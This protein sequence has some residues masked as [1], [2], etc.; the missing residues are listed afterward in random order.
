MCN[1][2][3]LN[4]NKKYSPQKIIML[5]Y[6]WLE[7]CQVEAYKCRYKLVNSSY[8][9]DTKRTEKQKYDSCH[10]WLAQDRVFSCPRV[11]GMQLYSCTRV[12]LAVKL[13][14]HSH[15]I[16]QPVIGLYRVLTTAVYKHLWLPGAEI[17]INTNCGGGWPS[18]FHVH[19]PYFL[20]IRPSPVSGSISGVQTFHTFYVWSESVAHQIMN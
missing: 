16:Y 8:K 9:C 5:P 7:D 14:P 13:H 11:T 2:D 6:T 3:L 15:G 17:L 20:N 19:E 12:T 1:H 4:L 18:A 10:W